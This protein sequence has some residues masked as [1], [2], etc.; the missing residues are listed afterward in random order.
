MKIDLERPLQTRCGFEVRD[1]RRSTYASQP[2]FT[3]YVVR[4]GRTQ[5]CRWDHSGNFKGWEGKPVG[6]GDNS[7]YDL[8]NS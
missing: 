5:L 7:M 8:V 1:V 3:G 4:S 2:P 6:R